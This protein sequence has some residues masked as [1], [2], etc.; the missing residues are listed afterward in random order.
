MFVDIFLSIVF[1]PIRLGVFIYDIITFPI[2]YAIL[3]PWIERYL[4]LISLRL[5]S[6]T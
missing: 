6:S 5:F 4:L 2:Y 1:I 3:K